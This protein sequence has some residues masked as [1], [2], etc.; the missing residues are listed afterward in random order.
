MQFLTHA[1]NGSMFTV[2]RG[3]AERGSPPAEALPPLAGT[4]LSLQP[5]WSPLSALYGNASARGCCRLTPQLAGG[6]CYRPPR[7]RLPR[8]SSTVVPAANAAAAQSAPPRSCGGRVG[9][10]HGVVHAPAKAPSETMR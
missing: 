9:Q 4:A 5:A 3:Y 7:S 8:I 2:A 1:L 10:S 6:R